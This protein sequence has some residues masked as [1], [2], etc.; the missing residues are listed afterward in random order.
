MP[1][2]LLFTFVGVLFGLALGW[3]LASSRGRPGMVRQLAETK[4]RGVRAMETVKQEV[5]VELAQRDRELDETRTKLEHELHAVARMQAEV[6][7]AVDQKTRMSAELAAVIDESFREIGQLYEIGS[8]LEGA[9]QAVEARLLAA[10][11]RL[12]EMGIEAG[13]VASISPH[14]DAVPETPEHPQPVE[15]TGA[16]SE[17]VRASA[18]PQRPLKTDS[19]L[20]TRRTTPGR[21]QGTR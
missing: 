1:N 6:K 10:S 13:G 21:P 19:V 2:D 16:I 11:K 17:A 18:P 14:A 5:A 4:V 8:A 12:R 9:V 15:S 20:P 7:H 3:W